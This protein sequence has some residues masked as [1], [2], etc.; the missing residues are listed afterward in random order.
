[1]NPIKRQRGFTLI[2]MALAGTMGLAVLTTGFALY[3][4][5][6]RT[7]ITQSDS[8]DAQMTIDYIVSSVRTLAVSAGGGLPQAANGL[9]HQKNAKG[10][11]VYYNPEDAST[12]VD[13]ALNTNLTDGV[14]P[15]TD[16]TLFM[17]AGYVLVMNDTA[18]ALSAIGS[19]D[20]ANDKITLATP[21][22][23]ANL[24]Q[25]DL[26]YPVY[27]CSLYVDGTGNLRKSFLG[28][29]ASLKRIPLA[30]N[31]DSLNISYDV[32]SEGNGA[33][34]TTLTDANKIS[35]VKIFVR[36]RPSHAI[37]G[38]R[39]RTFETI[40]GIRRGRLYNRTI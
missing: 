26:V 40:I 31:I 22:I 30:Q 3:R 35:R 9:R 6:T 24:G 21:S 1:M 19:V 20:W 4:Y 15:V 36:I 39:N 11:T 27:Y 34:I 37:A 18:T 25:I 17:E 28:Q 2:E 33:F 14:L 10:L 29:G 5:Q 13:Q 16:I 8:T 12:T 23:E 32:S 7:Q 38:S